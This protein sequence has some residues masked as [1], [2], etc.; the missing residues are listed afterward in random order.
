MW[1][2]ESNCDS[3]PPGHVSWELPIPRH[4]VL[5]LG[6]I[7]HLWVSGLGSVTHLWVSG[8]GSVTHLRVSGLR[9]VAH[10]WV[11]G[12]GSVAHL[13]VSGLGSVAHL[14]VSGLGSVAHLW[15]SGLRS[16]AHL[17]V[18]GVSW[19]AVDG[20]DHPLAGQLAATGGLDHHS[21]HALVGRYKLVVHLLATQRT[22]SAAAGEARQQRAATAT[23]VLA[24]AL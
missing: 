9:S 8:L 23:A 7:V 19:P 16:V 20:D 17:R 3:Q 12:L 14:R 21:R 22:V 6:S 10:L 13:W 5:G 2:R 15:V 11:S 18:S 1:R 24:L 4:A